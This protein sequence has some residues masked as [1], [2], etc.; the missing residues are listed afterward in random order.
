MLSVAKQKDNVKNA[1]LAKKKMNSIAQIGKELGTS[2][3]VDGKDV[4]EL[5]LLLLGG[6][7]GP[8]GVEDERSTVSLLRVL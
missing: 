1:K 5:L 2:V 4:V 8:K 7:L 6:G 3:I